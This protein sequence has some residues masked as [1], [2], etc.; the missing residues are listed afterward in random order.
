MEVEHVGKR[1]AALL[2][3]LEL[4]IDALDRIGRQAA[5]VVGQA[6]NEMLGVG[7]GVTAPV[8]AVAGTTPIMVSRVTSAASSSS[9]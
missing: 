9:L 3:R 5:D 4:M 8:A 2:P 7:H 6:L 1:V